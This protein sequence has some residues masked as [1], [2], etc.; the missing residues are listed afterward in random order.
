MPLNGAYIRWNVT[1]TAFVSF[2]ISH[3]QDSLCRRSQVPGADYESRIQLLENELAQALQANK[4]HKSQL[5]RYAMTHF[6]FL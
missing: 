5:D 1:I 6:L 3:K 2:Q 4:A